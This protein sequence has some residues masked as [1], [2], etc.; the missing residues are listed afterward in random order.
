M[1]LLVVH[2]EWYT[3]LT[4]EYLRERESVCVCVC[5]CVSR[6]VCLRAM[7]LLS[8]AVGLLILADTVCLGQ[9]MCDDACTV[10]CQMPL[11]LPKYTH[12]HVRMTLLIHVHIHL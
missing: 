6:A 2:I 4:V 3:I 12:I 10:S 5:V 11:Y 1:R 7:L 9:L 8:Q